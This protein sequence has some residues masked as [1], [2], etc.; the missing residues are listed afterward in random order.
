MLSD[1]TFTLLFLTQICFVAK[2]KGAYWQILI[3]KTDVI[4]LIF[5]LLGTAP[6]MGSTLWQV[7]K[8]FMDQVTN[9]V[10]KVNTKRQQLSAKIICQLNI[11]EYG[12]GKILN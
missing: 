12:G 7:S 11:T 2:G 1:L 5:R 10:S 4:V 6:H 3:T 8:Y 9:I